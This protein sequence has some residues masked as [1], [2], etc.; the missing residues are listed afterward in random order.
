MVAEVAS[1]PWDRVSIAGSGHPHTFTGRTTARP[2]SR[3]E[4]TRETTLL[5]SGVNEVLLLKSTGSAFK[6]YPRCEYTTLPETGD[7]IMATQMD[8][9]WTF[10]PDERD[11]SAANAAILAEL[12]RVFAEEF[13]PSLQNTLYL[14]GGAALAAVPSIRD[15]HLAMPN[16]HFLPVNL[17]PFGI[18]PN[19]ELFLPT[20]EPH[21]Q[22]EARVVR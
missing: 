15:I 9:T 22:I 2:F 19:D 18:D 21:G 20:D 3:V 14:M 11:F 17:K 16:K 12:V 1:W 13:S 7:R 5:Q 8:A 6:G 4:M 10:E